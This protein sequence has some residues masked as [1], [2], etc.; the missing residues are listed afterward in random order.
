MQG[1]GGDSAMILKNLNIDATAG[2][3]PA[4]ARRLPSIF[5]TISKCCSC[6]DDHRP[7]LQSDGI[8][9]GIIFAFKWYMTQSDPATRIATT[10]RVNTKAAMFQDWLDEPFICRK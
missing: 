10:I 3:E 4:A 7:G 6:W 8:I 5:H 2:S 9:P 1:N